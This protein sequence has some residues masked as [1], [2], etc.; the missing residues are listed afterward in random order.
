MAFPNLYAAAAKKNYNDDYCECI[1]RCRL[2][3]GLMR[4]ESNG[5][6]KLKVALEDLNFPS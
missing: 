2:R 3:L 5:P 4:A 6:V 1:V